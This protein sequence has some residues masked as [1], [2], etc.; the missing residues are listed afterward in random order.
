MRIV[1][2]SLIVLMLVWSSSALAQERA[3]GGGPAVTPPSGSES[4][5]S[6]GVVA[7]KNSGGLSGAAVVNKSEAQRNAGE[8][9]D[10][11]TASSGPPSKASRPA[12]T[13]RVLRKMGVDRAMAAIDSSVRACASESTSAA[14]VNVVARVAVRAD[15][16]V[17]D[18]EASVA[19]STTGSP[20]AL[21]SC[22]ARALGG[23]R[24]GSPGAAG[25]SLTVP[26]TVP[27]RPAP[28]AGDSGAAAT[29]EAKADAPGVG[30]PA[31]VAMNK[32]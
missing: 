19:P 6:S 18:V 4:S 2:S 13:P 16:T 28:R 24:F 31:A 7:P 1:P 11:G 26:L 5:V 3:P 15:G 9:R 8:A 21:I 23:S 12:P 27:G 30:A 29:P 10:V 32:P 25:A 14:P 20:Q 17:E 22:V